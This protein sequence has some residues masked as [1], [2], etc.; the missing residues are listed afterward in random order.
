MQGYFEVLIQRRL[1]W[2]WLKGKSTALKQGINLQNCINVTKFRVYDTIWMC[3]VIK[4]LWSTKMATWS[5]V[6]LYKGNLGYLIGYCRAGYIV[7]INIAIIQFVCEKFVINYWENER[8]IIEFI[9][10]AIGVT[11]IF[12]KG[13]QKNHIK[14]LNF[15]KLSHG[16]VYASVY[17]HNYYTHNWVKETIRIIYI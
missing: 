3:A 6:L 1:Y 8:N 5:W 10:C 11:W 7:I 2:N 17:N 16:N 13:I 15:T 9:G 4:H 14:T 12:W